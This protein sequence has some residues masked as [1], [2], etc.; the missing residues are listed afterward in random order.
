METQRG[1]F[2]FNDGGTYIGH[3]QRGC[4]HGLG[5]S[6]GPNGVGEYSGRWDAGFET[7]GVYVWP[8]GNSYAGTWAKGK[9]H[10][11]GQQ[12][13]GRWLYQGQF[14]DGVCGPLGV[15]TTLNGKSS[16]EGCWSMNR[17]EGYGIETCSDG[18]IYAGGWSKG[19][20]HGLGV[21]RSYLGPR[22]PTLQ[23]QATDVL[24]IVSSAAETMN[25]PTNAVRQ[26]TPEIQV[27]AGDSKCAD[28]V[29]EAR[30]SRKA[31]IGRSIM[32]RLRKQYSA[33][34]LGYSASPGRLSLACKSP[35][36]ISALDPALCSAGTY[37]EP[38]ETEGSAISVATANSEGSR[39]I[40]PLESRDRSTS[41]VL[42]VYA[43]EWYED[44]RSGYGVW[45]C[46]T[47]LRYLGEWVDNQRHGYGILHYPDGTQDEG[48]F[49]AN[50]LST[51]VNRKN[52][53]HILRQNKLKDLVEL[54]VV[55]ATAAANEARNISAEQAREK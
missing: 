40:K 15:K 48:Q 31:Q 14:T 18:S 20:R 39:K 53:I 25:Q 42:E 12:I 51:R 9:R 28:T 34:E 38:T 52:K 4:A 24:S 11:V 26:S 19:L 41:A 8:N 5:M 16:Y 55:R 45:I 13:R 23:V 7:C 6:T 47:G 33:M 32:K 30:V 54:T 37:T 29:D 10:G 3:W 17:F 46:S 49:L 36:P 2:D 44:K 27:S 50:Q 35:A 21:R 43:G 1:R 22:T